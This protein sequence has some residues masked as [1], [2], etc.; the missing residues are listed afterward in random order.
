VEDGWI[1]RSMVVVAC[2]AAGT[3]F[4]GQTPT[5]SC[6]GW[7]RDERGCTVETEVTTGNQLIPVGQEPTGISL[8]PTGIT[9]SRRFMAY[10]RRLLASYGRCIKRCCIGLKK[11]G[12]NIFSN[13]H[14][15]TSASFSSCS[16]T[17]LLI[18]LAHNYL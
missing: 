6:S 16:I 5:N 11:P 8:K 1:G 18:S 4:S 3:G 12:G 17:S 13:L 10:S 2:A 15:S 9:Y 14:K 7:A